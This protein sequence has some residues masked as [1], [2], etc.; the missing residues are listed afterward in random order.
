MVLNDLKK[1]LELFFCDLQAE[2]TGL[3]LKKM[4]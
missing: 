1:V 3:Y 4:T 2:R